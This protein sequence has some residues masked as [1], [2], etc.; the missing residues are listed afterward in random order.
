MVVPASCQ[1]NMGKKGE[2]WAPSLIILRE[3]SVVLAKLLPESKLR[4]ANEKYNGLI[5][6][7]RY[8]ISYT[9]LEYFSG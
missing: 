7:Q 4:L 2:N 3:P 8:R 6:G 1:I 5:K 9:G